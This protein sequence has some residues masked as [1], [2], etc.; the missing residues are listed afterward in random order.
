MLTVASP[1]WHL[2]FTFE[3]Q[4][5]NV[6][7]MLITSRRAAH[8]VMP[9]RLQVLPEL[10]GWPQMSIPV[11]N[12]LPMLGHRSIDSMDGIAHLLPGAILITWHHLRDQGTFLQADFLPARRLP[13][14][15]P[16]QT[17]RTE[18]PSPVHR[19]SP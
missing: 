13:L 4:A 16:R 18:T 9:M 10:A 19:R 12:D 5:H 7:P 14:R 8:N 17:P 2:C 15:R 6:M 1:S 11:A 3:Q